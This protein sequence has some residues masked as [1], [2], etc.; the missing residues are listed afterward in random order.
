MQLYMGMSGHAA[1]VKSD[2]SVFA[3]IHPSGSAPMPA[4]ALANPSNPHAGHMMPSMP[5][6]AGGGPPPEVA[7]PYGFPQPGAYRIFVQVKRGG[8]IEAGAFDVQ[9]AN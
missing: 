2:G 9:A 4:L 6:M 8:V 1:F 7:F 5:D 3:H